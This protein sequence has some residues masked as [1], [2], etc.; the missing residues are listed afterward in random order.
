[1]I[2]PMKADVSELRVEP[3]TRTSDCT[4]SSTRER[5]GMS[6]T[7]VVSG[8]ASG[9]GAATAK[10]LRERGDTVI[11]IDLHDAEVVADLSRRE[12]RAEAA[13]ATCAIAGGTIDAVIA[14]A[15]ISAPIPQTISVNFFGVTELLCALR[16][17]L[18]TS[19]APRAA[20]VSSVASYRP[21]SSALVEAAIA[22]DEDE[23]LRLA[24]L[25]T[26]Q[27]LATA[28]Q[29][30]TASKRAL[31]RWV[32]A[33]SVSDEWA[34]AGIPLN[35]VAPGAV[36]TPMTAGSLSTPEGIAAIDAAVPMPLNY[37]QAP[38]TIARLL[39]WLVSVENTHM[40]GQTVYCDGGADVMV[41]GDDI[42]SWNDSS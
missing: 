23:A 32:R 29:V 38:E 16:P 41:R 26:T 1:M 3:P 15:G 2:E 27:D 7:Y 40:A 5:S 25:L 12:G 19:D 36:V 13:R 42:W 17:A 10:L 21:S 28:H 8:S 11:G 22:G 30:Y 24:G 20:V 35:A 14:C 31:S 9:I 39:I 37:H 4:P 34:G 33:R 18:L 6:R